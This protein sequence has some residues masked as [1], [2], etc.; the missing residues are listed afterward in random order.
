MRTISPNVVAGGPRN[1]AFSLIEILVTVALLTVIILG[2]VAMFNQTRKAFTSSFTQVDVLESG[3]STADILAREM[4]QMAPYGVS[5]IAN[6]YVDSPQMLNAFPVLIQPLVTPNDNRTNL[7]EEVFYLTVYN[8]QWTC[9]GYKLDN[10]AN[11]IGSL[12]RFT[13]NI[14]NA[15]SL[16]NIVSNFNYFLAT[17]PTYPNTN[18]FSRLIDG[19]VDFRIHALD[20]NGVGFGYFVFNG[21]YPS[22]YINFPGQLY[23]Y[24]M[25]TN[26]QYVGTVAYSASVAVTNYS[27]PSYNPDM[28]GDFSYKFTSNSIPAY[29]ELELGVLEDRTLARYNAFTN[30]V[31]GY[32]TPAWGY[33][34]NHAGQVHLFRQRIPIRNV[35]PAAFQ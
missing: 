18:G 29:V 12:Y 21:Q 20:A 31:V 2:L 13:A 9:V 7:L 5:N 26:S 34:T 14:N 23:P 33:L 1:S 22:N 32:N 19:V 24:G 15:T 35:N 25:G 28:S 4:E 8:Q 16:K 27:S 6:F 11:G 30:A 10:Y 17:A 3:R